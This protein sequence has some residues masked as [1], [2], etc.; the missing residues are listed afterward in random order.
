MPL[1]DF[2]FEWFAGATSVAL[3]AQTPA[4]LFAN[5]YSVVG[6]ITANLPGQGCVADGLI[7]LP[8]IL[9]TIQLV[10]SVTANNNC[11]PFDGTI[12]F[13][14]IEEN[15]G[16]VGFADYTNFTVFDDGL[17]AIVPSIGDGIVVPWGEIA[18]GDY[19]LQAQNDITKCFTEIKQVSVVDVSQSP[20][21]SISL[22][23]LDYGCTLGAATGELEAFSTAGN[24]NIADYNFTWHQGDVSSPVVSNL[25][26]ASNITAYSSTQLYTIEIEDIIGANLGCVASEDIPWLINLL[27]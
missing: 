9:D 2:S 5:N 3:G 16:S 17:P 13:V 12:Q 14:D 4:I 25:P 21:I 27:R 23:N 20:V 10:E 26:L 6:E 1:A 7:S 8:K 18:P 24:Q 19:Y 15:G 11:A 22:N